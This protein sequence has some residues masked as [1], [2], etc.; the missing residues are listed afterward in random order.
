M[1]SDGAHWVR[2]ALQVNPYAYE[3]RN[4][5]KNFF[6]NEED[7]NEALLNECQVQQISLIAIT[8]HWCVDSA[9]GLVDAAAARGIVALPGFEAN[10]SEGIHVLVIFEADT[11]FSAVNAAIGACGGSPGCDNGTVGASYAVIMEKMTAIGA[12][13]VPAHVNVKPAG[14]LT[15]RS[16]QPLA[17]MIKHPDLHAIGITPTTEETRD[18]Q[19]VVGGTGLFERT[20]PLAVIH[21]D[22]VMGPRQ[23]RTDGS[24]SWFK[25]STS[26]LMSLK[27]AVRTPETRVSLTDPAV[28]PRPVIRSV[29]WVGGYLDGVKIPISADL[30]ALI[31]GRGAGKSTVIES[32]RYALGIDAISRQMKTDHKNMVDNVLHAGTIVRLEVDSV[33]PTTQRFTIERE[34]P[35]PPVV[36]D[37]GGKRTKLTP[38]DAIGPVEIFGQHELAELAGD[39]TSV[40][41][42]V[43]RFDGSSSGDADLARALVKLQNNREDLKRAEDSELEL[44]GELAQVGRLEEQVSHYEQ[45]DVPAKLAGQQRLAQDQAIFKEGKARVDAARH[46]YDTFLHAQE[47]RDLAAPID[48]IERAPQVARLQRVE[49]AITQLHLKLA[50]LHAQATQAISAADAEIEAARQEWEAATADELAGYGEVLREL[51]EKG[52]QPDKYV[53]TK[54]ELTELRTSKPRLDAQHEEIR[55]LLAQRDALLGELRTHETRRTEQ[56]QT[57][58]R[59]ANEATGG[60]VVVRPVPTSDRSSILDVIKNHT[61]NQRTQI[62]AAVNAADFSPKALSTAIRTG[63]DALADFD[64]RGAQA[65]GLATAGEALARELEEL[66]VDLA[67]EVKLKIDGSSGLRT[68]DQ[69]SK[70]QRATALLLLL[71]GASN[72]PLII[73]QPED[74]LDNNFVY[75]GIV[76]NLRILKGKRQVITSTHNANVPVLGDAELIIALEGDGTHGKP[77]EGGIGSLDDKTIRALAENILEG[78]PAAFNAR[79]H[80]Y[81]F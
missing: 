44:E 58:V 14:M 43:R 76:R 22:D 75:K 31:G 57:A 50:E 68:M 70:G 13:P 30:T 32:I 54:A 66:S 20:H 60:V 40:A 12:L 6:A 37:S 38:Q 39:S 79:H 51:N 53:A 65:A 47:V 11:D 42:L 19:A 74:D 17:T 10:S 4:A 81:G 62:T 18:Q 77:S 33:T 23:L 29:S 46:H 52:L 69:L 67:V 3:G 71:L 56:L 45:T 8:D 5:P 48:D 16:G 28:A 61:S 34:V 59:A 49:A 27:L 55:K 15:T 73:D 36:L 25:V 72:A 2:A 78:G 80:L 7:Y 21:A 63:A 24:S 9:R 64:I 41:E 35:H 1:T 26:S